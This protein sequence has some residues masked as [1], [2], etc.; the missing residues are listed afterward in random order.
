MVE[1]TDLLTGRIDPPRAAQ[2]LY[3]ALEAAQQGIED[4]DEEA[5]RAKEARGPCNQ[6]GCINYV[7]S[8]IPFDSKCKSCKHK[9]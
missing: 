9:H 1:P 5:K 8:S 6:C 3:D 4:F 2:P 7:E